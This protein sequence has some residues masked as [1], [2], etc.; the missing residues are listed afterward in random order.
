M[1]VSCK[2]AASVFQENIGSVLFCDGKHPKVMQDM[3][4]M[5]Y[6]Q[7]TENI[8]CR[9][10]VMPL[11]DSCHKQLCFVLLYVHHDI[12]SIHYFCMFLITKQY[13]RIIAF[14]FPALLHEISFIKK[15]DIVHYI[16]C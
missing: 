5:M 3:Y 11:R 6:M 16:L 1:T 15:N 9:S 7:E 12:Y 4:I 10:G 13:T 14:Y 2:S 8:T